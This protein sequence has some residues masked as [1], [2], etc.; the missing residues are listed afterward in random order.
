MPY[1]LIVGGR[2]LENQQ[3]AVRLRGGED[4]GA[5]SLAAFTEILNAEMA[6]Y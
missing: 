2:E 5:M 1:L 4:K 6:D 3:V